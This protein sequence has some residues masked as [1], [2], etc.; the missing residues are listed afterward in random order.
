[1]HNA[2][3]MAIKEAETDDNEGIMPN[4]TNHYRT[5]SKGLIQ[6]SFTTVCMR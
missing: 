2:C 4:Q 6:M 5:L 1:M 3:Y